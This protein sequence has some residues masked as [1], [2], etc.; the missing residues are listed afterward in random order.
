MMENPGR[1]GYRF[2]FI[3]KHCFVA[4]LW[5]G[6]FWKCVSEKLLS[7]MNWPTSPE[8]GVPHFGHYFKAHLLYLCPSVCKSFNTLPSFLFHIFSPFSLIS[9]RYFT[10]F[11]WTIYGNLRQFRGTQ[12]AEIHDIFSNNVLILFLDSLI[13]SLYVCKH[14][15]IASKT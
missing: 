12:M 15:Y 11:H 8:F 9:L 7:L 4:D 1:P 14:G 6:I 10:W 13:H 3:S 2:L 5:E